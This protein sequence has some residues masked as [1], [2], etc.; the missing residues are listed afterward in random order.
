[1]KTDVELIMAL[2]DEIIN[3]LIENLVSLKAENEDLRNSLS[4][5][6]YILRLMGVNV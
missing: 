2:D 4:A 1:M 6:R 3:T 5:V